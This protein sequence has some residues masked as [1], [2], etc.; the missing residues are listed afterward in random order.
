MRALARDGRKVRGLVRSEAGSSFVASLGADA[1]MGTL[2]D[3]AALRAA[4]SGVD[5][6]VHCAAAVGADLRMQVAMTINAEGT[7]L[8][9][10]ALRA[11]GVSRFVH[12][13]SL[14][15][16]GRRC[17]PGSDESAPTTPSGDPYGDSKLEAERRVEAA[18]GTLRATIVR[19]GH[20]CGP[21]D[22]HFVPPLMAALERGAFRWVGD[23]GNRIDALHVDDA[24]RAIAM[25]VD[26]DDIERI[27]VASAEPVTVRRLITAICR[28]A[29]IAEPQRSISP[30]AAERL[31]AEWGSSLGHAVALDA[32]TVDR[33]LDLSMMRDVL[34][35]T[36]SATIEE[37]IE[38]GLASAGLVRA[39]PRGLE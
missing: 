16:L 21:R 1:V 34:G 19:P 25:V 8:L 31:T 6:V 5:A 38:A 32:M 14:R 28:C 24:A 15:V 22:R 10:D 20:L 4:V 27:H 36:P 29:N 33:R 26:R 18:A 17:A 7:Q 9:L 37:A 12:V 35:F 2:L 3:G 23:G 30:A 39:N 11:E 13:S